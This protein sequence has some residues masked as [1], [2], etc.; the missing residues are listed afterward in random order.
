MMFDE[1]EKKRIPLLNCTTT[2]ENALLVDLVFNNPQLGPKQILQIYGLKQALKIMTPRELRNL[3]AHSSQRSW[4]RLM[5][6]A[7]EVNLTTHS[8]FKELRKIIK[9]FKP[10]SQAMI[11]KQKEKKL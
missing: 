3:F 6:S 1:L 9:I 8:P 2:N 7:R 5:T 11:T 4:Y 10:L